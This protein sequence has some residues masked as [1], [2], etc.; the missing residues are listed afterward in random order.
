MNLDDAAIDLVRESL[1]MTLKI[2]APILL[3]GVLVGLVVSVF[4]SITSIQDQTLAFVPKIVA[5]V[6]G[7]LLLLPWIIGLLT[8]YARELFSLM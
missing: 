6:G 4:Q 7:T 2:G 1:L 5:M 3:L 8:E